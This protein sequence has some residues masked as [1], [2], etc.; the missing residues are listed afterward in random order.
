M[1]DVTEECIN[2]WSSGQVFIEMF[3]LG[4][5]FLWLSLIIFCQSSNQ[6]SAFIDDGVVLYNGEQIDNRS[7]SSV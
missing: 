1:R 2:P 6:P 5:N 3:W 7:E 4:R